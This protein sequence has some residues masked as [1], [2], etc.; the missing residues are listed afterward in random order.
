MA[1]YAFFNSDNVVDEVIVGLSEDDLI[2]GLPPAEWYANF[3]GKP[4]VQ[5]SY[6]THGGIHYGA[7]GKP[8]AGVPLY[9]NYAGIG[10]LF[11]GIGFYEPQPFPSWTLDPD[12]YWWM[13]PVPKPQGLGWIWDEE[14]LN[15][16]ESS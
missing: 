7:D 15:W 1:H 6:N 16:I 12:T 4:C 2:E 8:D 5:T 9:K 14:N 13:P 3:R 10:Y 11:D